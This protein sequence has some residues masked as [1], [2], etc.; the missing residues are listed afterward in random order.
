MLIVLK[1]AAIVDRYP[2]ARADMLMI[3][4]LIGILEPTPAANVVD[5]DS[6]EFGLAGRN[7]CHQALQCFTAIEA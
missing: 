6:L 3:G 1:L 7:F 5:E 2:S 4:A